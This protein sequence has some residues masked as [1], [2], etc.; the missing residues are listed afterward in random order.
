MTRRLGSVLS[1]AL[2]TLQQGCSYTTDNVVT[3]SPLQTRH[4]VSAS[5]S[6]V[7]PSGKI[8][9]PEQYEVLRSFALERT[10]DSPRHDT[11]SSSLDLGPDIERVL[12]QSGGTA[13]TNVRVE[14][15]DYDRGSHRSAATWKLLGF[16]FGGTGLALGA[17]GATEHEG[18]AQTA[19]LAGGAGLFVVGILCYAVSIITDEPSRWTFHVSGNAVRQRDEPPVDVVA[20]R[21]APAQP[22]LP[23]VDEATPA[24]PDDARYSSPDGGAP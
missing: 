16:Y 3:F 24:T 8:V 20:P 17:V 7:A 12:V 6:Y 11:G 22:T 13:A 21:P 2:A 15:T 4:P 9:R 1:A 10:V 19:A 18:N 23:S 5:Q 14:A